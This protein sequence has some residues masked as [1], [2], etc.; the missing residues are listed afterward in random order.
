MPRKLVQVKTLSSPNDMHSL[1]ESVFEKRVDALTTTRFKKKEI[2]Q[3]MFKR[4]CFHYGNHAIEEKVK[5]KEISGTRSAAV[6]QTQERSVLQSRPFSLVEK[7]RVEQKKR[8]SCSEEAEKR[9]QEGLQEG[10]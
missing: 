4:Q 7:N 10:L 6:H 5:L 2:T 9:L 8:A 3:H 1:C